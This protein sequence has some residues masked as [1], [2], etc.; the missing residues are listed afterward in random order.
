MA[1][2]GSKA[3]APQG[4]E[5]RSEECSADRRG[6]SVDGAQVIY[7]QGD[8]SDTLDL[9]AVG[10]LNIEVAGADGLRLG[11]RRVMTN[12]V[13]GEMGFFRQ[14]ARSASVV[15]D[16]MTL[17]ATLRCQ[18][19]KAAKRRLAA[20]DLRLKVTVGFAPQTGGSVAVVSPTIAARE[21]SG[22]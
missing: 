11:V 9:V 7:N 17:A 15:S 13:V 2:A 8:P 6:R 19:S 12:T 18:L 10:R 5:C 20:G 22:D 3:N 14:S 21:G 4:I 16:V 1:R